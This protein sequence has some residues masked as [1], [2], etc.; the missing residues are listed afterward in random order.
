[1]RA[2]G[3]GKA[4]RA[5]YLSEMV[6]IY[7][8]ETPTPGA[9]HSTKERNLKHLKSISSTPKTAQT[10][11]DILSLVASLLQVLGAALVSKEAAE[12]GTGSGTQA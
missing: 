6:L 12:N 5:L 8:G 11:G 10:L 1:M 4:A 2:S 7:S 9:C 3:G